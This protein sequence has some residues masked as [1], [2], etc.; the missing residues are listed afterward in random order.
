VIRFGVADLVVVASEVLDLDTDAVLVLLDLDAAARA[1]ADPEPPVEDPPGRAGAM[2]HGLLHNR[3][4]RQGNRRVALIA[5]TQ[6]LAVNGWQLD[7]DPPEDLMRVLLA[8]DS[9]AELAAWMRQR[10]HRAGTRH[11]E[12]AMFPKSTGRAK[13]LRFT[14]FTERARRVVVLAQEEAR[15]HQRDHIGTEHLLLGL[16]HEGRGLAAQ[17]LASLGIDLDDVR[18]LV[19]EIGGPGRQAP[20]GHLPFTARGRK[21]L[22]LALRE[23]LQLSDSSVGTEHLLLGL[24]GEADGVAAQ[25]LARLGVTLD[26]V[27]D[28]VLGL[29]AQPGSVLPQERAL[30]R[31]IDRLRALLRDAGIDP[32][33]GTARTA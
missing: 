4:L 9:P 30:R 11:E 22:D 25:V 20:S 24:T 1:L 6:F 21:V 18:R 10:L 29:T 14:R 17:A 28:R 26:E 7:I 31:E 19:A 13:R 33:S 2:L 12:R 8:A 15:M 5:T 16:I 27:R 32:D 23:A 3:P